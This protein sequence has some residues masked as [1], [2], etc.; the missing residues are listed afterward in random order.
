[1][2]EAFY[3]LREKPF[4][5]LPDPDL[6]FWGR[7]HTM[8]FTMLEF[9]VMNNA[10]FTVIT[11]EIGSGKTTLVRYLLKRLS[12]NITTALISNSPQGRHE[13]LQWIMMSLGQPFEGDY[14][15]L[16][17]KFQDLLHNQY[18][19]RRRTILIM[20]EAQNLEAEALE[21]LRMLSNINADKHQILQLVLVGQTQL[22]DLL[23]Q[24]RL[25][26][27]AQR[28]SS[29]FHL[30]PL[31]EDEVAKYIFFR[32]HA[33]GA[34]KPLFTRDACTTIAHASGG[35][36]RMI[37]ILCDTALVYGFSGQTHTISRAL[38]EDVVRDKVEYSLYPIRSAV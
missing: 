29:D 16:F 12:P 11:G 6:I 3:G 9:G 23:L 17:K 36:P 8:A 19:A 28:I 20:D 4:S 38:V 15:W 22:R 7:M 13:L 27:F 5:I 18:A 37:N 1:M 14:P 35:L 31:N 30:R 26:Q 10:G 21:H 24:P 32:L 25:H 33:V 34:R 2:Y